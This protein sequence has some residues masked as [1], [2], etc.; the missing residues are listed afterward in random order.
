M[1]ARFFAVP[2][3]YKNLV[4]SY[5][6]AAVFGVWVF[7]RGRYVGD[8]LGEWNSFSKMVAVVF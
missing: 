3:L 4:C 6:C 8:Q 5:E 7:E 1:V 2:I